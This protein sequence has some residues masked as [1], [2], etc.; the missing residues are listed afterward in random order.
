MKAEGGT[1]L[2]VANGPIKHPL[3]I[4]RLLFS[5]SLL[6][7]DASSYTPLLEMQTDLADLSKVVKPGGF[8]LF[9]GTVCNLPAYSIVNTINE[10]RNG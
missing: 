7:P 5:K 3:V 8:S 9:S 4:T 2:F 1:C 6:Q 10:G